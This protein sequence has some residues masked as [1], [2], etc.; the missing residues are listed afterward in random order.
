MQSNW[1]IMNDID[2]Q[3]GTIFWIIFNFAMKKRLKTCFSKKIENC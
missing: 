2:E 3:Y 1:A